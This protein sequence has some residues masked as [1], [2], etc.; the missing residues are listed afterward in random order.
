NGKVT[1]TTLGKD[2]RLEIPAD[3][4]S[5]ARAGAADWPTAEV[6]GR[7]YI[8]RLAFRPSDVGEGMVVGFLADRSVTSR[9]R[10]EFLSTLATA[11]A[12]MLLVLLPLIVLATHRSTR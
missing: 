3:V 1:A 2:A 12:V 7:G 4:M 10:G 11:G 6:D 5:A 9:S 8:A